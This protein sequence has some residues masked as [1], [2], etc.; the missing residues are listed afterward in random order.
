MLRLQG[1][2]PI[3]KPYY[4]EK[5]MFIEIT[6]NSRTGVEESRTEISSEDLLAKHPNVMDLSSWVYGARPGS[7]FSIINKG[8]LY[9]KPMV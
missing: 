4:R 9:E 2:L 5:H 3:K 7:K 1:E 8:F 6:L